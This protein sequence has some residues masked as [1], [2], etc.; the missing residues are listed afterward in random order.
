[1]TAERDGRARASGTSPARRRPT[2][3][4]PPCAATARC[5]GGRRRDRDRRTAGRRRRRPPRRYADQTQLPARRPR[6]QPGRTPTRRPTSRAWP[7]TGGFLWAVGSHSLRRRRIKARHNGDDALRRLAK[8]TGQANR[9]ILV[10][11]PVREVDG[12]PTLVRELV[13]DGTT[14]RAAILRLHGTDLRDL[15]ADDVHLGPV[16]ARSRARTTGWTSR[17][18]P[19]RRRV[20]LGLRGPVLRGWAVVLELRPDG[21]ARR[22]RPLRC[23]RSS[24]GRRTASTCCDLGGLGV[25]DLCPHGDG[26]C[27]C[28]P[29]RPWTSTAR[30]TSSA[31]AA[32]W[33]PTPRRSCAD[34][35]LTRDSTC[36]TAPAPTTRRGSG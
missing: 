33:R 10:R 4:S 7:G 20:Y 30:C 21:G 29:G 25:R 1:M 31:G 8:V 36:P 35:M 28:W 32:R 16:P 17:A 18:S 3:T 24:D 12:L 27:W 14:H 19:S 6:D 13:V 15:L 11:L 23:A 9:Q 34:E 2:P 26:T 5:W 22:A